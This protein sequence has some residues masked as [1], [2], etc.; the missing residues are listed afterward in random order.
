MSIQLYFLENYL[1]VKGQFYL[2]LLLLDGILFSSVIK[3]HEK[4]KDSKFK[5]KGSHC[6]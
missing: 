4:Y 1:I 3:K 2:Q 6:M 5:L